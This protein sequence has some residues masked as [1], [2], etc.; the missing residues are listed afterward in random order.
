MIHSLWLIFT[1]NFPAIYQINSADNINWNSFTTK[2]SGLCQTRWFF[3]LKVVGS[4]VFSRFLNFKI[5]CPFFFRTYHKDFLQLLTSFDLQWPLTINKTSSG[6]FIYQITMITSGS[7]SGFSF[8]S[9]HGCMHL[10]YH[11]HDKLLL[12]K[13][14]SDWMFLIGH[15]HLLVGI[16]ILWNW[17]FELRHL[18]DIL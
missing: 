6:F 7:T 16:E 8:H 14:R 3:W 1:E 4:K 10:S 11:L 15:R 17:N 13:K 12:S 5:F 2:K 9:N 18:A